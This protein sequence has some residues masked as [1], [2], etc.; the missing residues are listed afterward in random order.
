MKT[1]TRIAAPKFKVGKFVLNEYEMRQFQNEV[2]K[3]LR[4][5]N[6]KVKEVSTG[7]T[8]LL[9]HYGEFHPHA[10][11]SYGMSSG[12]TLEN[13]RF[14]RLYNTVIDNETFSVRLYRV[15]EFHSFTTVRELYDFVSNL[16]R[17]DKLKFGTL[18]SQYVRNSHIL[19]ELK[20]FGLHIPNL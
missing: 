8:Y 12:L 6:V 16:N 7:H 10:P 14:R 15:A 1:I 9:D 20:E 13:I 5:G 19:K 3:K 4:P 18:S 17:N 2:L 11:L